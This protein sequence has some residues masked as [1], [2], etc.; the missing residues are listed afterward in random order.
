MSD[1]LQGVRAV[2]TGSTRGLGE[3][4]V[5]DLVARG[6]SVVVNGTSEERCAALASEL[7]ARAV[8]GSVA[9]EAVA[10]A[11]VATCVDAYGGIDV[12]VNN[13]GVARDGMLSRMTA[14]QF[15][16][17]IAVHLRGTWL[18]A[19]AAA[20]AMKGTGGSI[21]NV[22]SGT[23]LFGNLAQSNYAAAKGG[24]LALTRS[25]SLEL[26]RLGIRVNAISPIVMTDMIDPLA[27]LAGDRWDEVA[28][29]FGSPEQVAPIVAF[30]ASPA[31]ADITGQVLGFNGRRLAVWSHPTMLRRVERD[32][33]SLDDMAAA[34]DG[35]LAELQP[36]E[37]GAAVLGLM[38]VATTPK[39][40]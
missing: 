13:A 23:A 1:A 16:E 29:L 33:W 15:D 11:L 30:L 38:G 28:A 7:G 35:D 32:A 6:A 21:V 3:A 39:L 8:P 12:L 25:L 24:I 26:A 14:E 27:G 18:A 10:D 37:L 20:R 2:V 34:L 40:P 19:R 4:V 36:D 5:R 9:D 31:S 17:V 22:T